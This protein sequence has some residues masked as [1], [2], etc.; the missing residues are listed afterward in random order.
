MQAETR[1]E[2]T[3]VM[4]GSVPI[5]S[6]HPVRVQSMTNTVT[7]KVEDTLDQIKLLAD[8][9]SELVRITINDTNAA[10]AV[11]E[12]VKRLRNEGY[13]VPIIGDFHY[14]GHIL[15]EKHPDMATAIDKYRIN[16]GNV[17]KGD[18]KDDNYS[19][20][21]NAAIKY[22]K[23]VRIGVNAGSID[24]D[25][26]DEHMDT[27]AK[28]STPKSFQEV[29]VDTM[30]DSA[31]ISL[32]AAKD[33]GL[34]EDKI[35]LSVKVSEL[36]EMVQAYRQLAPLCNVPLHL[37]LTEAGSSV[38]GLVSSAA[39]LGI[40]LQDGIGDT[41]RIS[42][43]PEPNVPRSREVDACIDLLQSMGL[44]SFRPSITSCPGC[45]RTDSDYFIHL[46]EDVDKHIKAKIKAWAVKYPGVE[47]LKVAVMGCVVNGPGES[48]YADIGISLPGIRETPTAPVYIDG[49]L[50]QTLKGENITQEF[51]GILDDYIQ[52]RFAG[53]SGQK[54]GVE[55]G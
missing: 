1:R 16:P 50:S 29:L 13:T 9:G 17:G 21:I 27:N 52:R 15:L 18:K 14:N 41:I 11:P 40:V 37:G 39:A 53:V 25:L 19:Q 24:Q 12:I 45:G 35:I 31:L 22:D 8:A 28:S 4:V 54:I 49:A 23:P 33:L 43:T 10:A 47:S 51:I 38:K 44:R 6:A 5:G 46:A 2:T 30:V 3:S 32:K 36:Q 26:L 7:A 20:I 42:L 48:K 34:S 55:Q